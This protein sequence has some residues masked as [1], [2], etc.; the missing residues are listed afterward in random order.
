[1]TFD[2]EKDGKNMPFTRLNTCLIYENFENCMGKIFERGILT[3]QF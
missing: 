2:L 3:N 1:M